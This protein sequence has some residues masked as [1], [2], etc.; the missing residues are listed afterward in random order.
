M[1]QICTSTAKHP[2]LSAKISNIVDRINSAFATLAYQPV[3]LLNQDISH[4]QYLALLAVADALLITSLREGMNLTS[5][6]FI[7]SQDGIIP[8]S[9]NNGVL[10]LSEFAGSS[11]VF[12]GFDLPVNPWNHRQCADAINKALIMEPEERERRWNG[13][14]DCVMRQD[15]RTWYK[16]FIEE[17]RTASSEQEHQE[18]LSVPRLSTKSLQ[19]AYGSS[20]RRLFLLDYE[21]AL[22]YVGSPTSTV[23]ATQQRTLNVLNKLVQ[24]P[25]NIVY[26]FSQRTPEE[27][28]QLLQAVPSIGLVAENGCFLK[29][30]GEHDWLQLADEEQAASA[31]SSVRD[32]LAHY[33]ERILGSSV[34]ELIV[35]CCC[36]STRLRT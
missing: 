7:Y 8:G 35:R 19:K 31:K 27:V 23:L 1:I 10:I 2:E 26:I 22:S 12:K 15:A 34:E 3:V 9:K 4:P 32:I 36:I 33:N 14:H 30:P 24:D 20:K 25:N 28:G 11:S 5:H 17:L 16:R 18:R 13:M 21:G 29:E 6:E